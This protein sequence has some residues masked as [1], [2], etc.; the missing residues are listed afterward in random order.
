MTKLFLFTFL[1][2]ITTGLFAKQYNIR[3]YGAISDTT[4]LSTLAIQQAI[5]ECNNNGG[6]VVAIPAGNYLIG[7]LLIKSNVHVFLE[8]GSTIYGSTN[9]KDY[10][11]IKADYSSLRTQEKTIQLIYAEKADNI[12]ISGFGEINGQGK[13]FPKLTWMDEGIT[14]P[15][16]LRFINCTNIKVEGISMKNSGC[17]MQHYLACT[18]LQIRGLTIE[19]HNNFNNDG[20]DIDG[21]KNVT[22]SDIISD[23]DDDA[24]VLKSTSARSCENV[25]ITNCVLSSHCNGIKLGTETNG[26]FRNITISNCIVK[27]SKKDTSNFFGKLTGIGGI[28]ILIVDGG[29][30]DGVTISNIQ[31]E[32]TECPIFVRLGNRARPFKAGDVIDHIGT[33]KNVIISNVQVR[34]TKNIGCSITGMPD[35]PIKNIQLNNINIEYEGGGADSLLSKT[36]DEKAKE[37]PEPTMFGQ[38]PAYGF[39]IRHAE[40]VQF[41]NVQLTT[42]TNDVR[43]AIFTD[44]VHFSKFNNLTVSTNEES[45]YTFKL[46]NSSDIVIES[47]RFIGKPKC[48]VEIEGKAS[49][50]ISLRN[51]QRITSKLINTIDTPLNLLIDV[52]KN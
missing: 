51:N 29:T 10:I 38:L 21:C 5:N 22:I 2:A 37:Y 16:L 19:N 42:K 7:T 20:L 32:G 9:I 41:N 17:W 48:M 40:N 13:H 31:I 25:S 35:H 6:G 39:Y 43:P 24:I 50:N 27:P 46:K 45:P 47:T 4:V 12:S 15:H 49:Q 11:E 3:D 8:E 34:N 52:E 1:L 23:T 30:L 36:I 33:I 26:G 28:V 18:N 44:D 14:R